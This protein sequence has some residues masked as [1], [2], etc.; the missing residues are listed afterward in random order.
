MLC[1]SATIAF[2]HLK[3]IFFFSSFVI[4]E[5]TNLLQIFSQST[6]NGLRFYRG[7][8]LPD[9]KECE[10]TALFCEW[11]NQLFDVLNRNEKHQG[12]KPGNSDY[13]VIWFCGHVNSSLR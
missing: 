4:V 3:L 8:G 2:Y 11:I 6:S 13:E 10:S 5:Q 12:L 7:L 1:R 9:F